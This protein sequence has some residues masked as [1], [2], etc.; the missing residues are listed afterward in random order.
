MNF[1]V[2]GV[3]APIAYFLLR[4][5][6]KRLVQNFILNAKKNSKVAE[7][8]ECQ[9][10]GVFKSVDDLTEKDNAYICKNN[11]SK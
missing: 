6:V 8:Q 1:I 10:C 4:M 9:K 3:I 11:C 2:V 7:V 5:F